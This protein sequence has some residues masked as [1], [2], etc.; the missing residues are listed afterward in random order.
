MK[1]HADNIHDLKSQFSSFASSSKN[2]LHTSHPG[3]TSVLLTDTQSD[4]GFSHSQTDQS[5]LHLP[6]HRIATVTV[7]EQDTEVTQDY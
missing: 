3:D 1:S 7:S 6:D 4:P 5:D 2:R